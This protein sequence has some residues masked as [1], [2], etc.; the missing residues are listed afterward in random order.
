MANIGASE[1][2]KGYLIEYKNGIWKVI[3]R[4]HVKPGKGGAFIQTELKN[5]K[6][7]TKANERFRSEDKVN[8]LLVD[9]IDAQFS[10]VDDGVAY[11]VNLEN[12]EEMSLNLEDIGEDVDFLIDDLKVKIE[13]VDEKFIGII[14]PE[15][16][17]LT[18]VET[19]PEIKG[20][21][22]TN[23]MKKAVMSNGITISVPGFIANEE[24]LIVSTT[25]R[26][27]VKRA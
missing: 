12:Y 11:F 24:K 2:S 20:S 23:V 13:L 22:V 21:T 19:D 5:I 8:R 27:Y 18:V 10:Y 1:L 7:G 3:S 16:V 15:S 25:T 26:E 9:T 6:T 14:L 4:Q 17:V